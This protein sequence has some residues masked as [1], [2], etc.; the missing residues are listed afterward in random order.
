MTKTFCNRLKMVVIIFSSIMSLAIYLV[1]LESLFFFY[2][3]SINKR[4]V[5][6]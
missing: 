4:I 6:Y 1:E 3:R 2:N 5:H